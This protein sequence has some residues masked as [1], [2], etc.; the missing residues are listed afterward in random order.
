MRACCDQ[1]FMRFW[2]WWEFC[3]TAYS[4]HGKPFIW[5]TRQVDDLYGWC[6]FFLK[7][8]MDPQQYTFQ[9]DILILYRT[10][11]DK[12]V[13]TI[14]FSTLR[15]VIEAHQVQQ[16]YLDKKRRCDD[17]WQAG[18][19]ASWSG[20]WTWISQCLQKKVPHL[21]VPTSNLPY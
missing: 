8:R 14:P 4:L 12:P 3:F 13:I 11:N 18:R 1:V 21:Q 7:N 6:R 5:N 10:S 16:T 9:T 2:T 15:Q 19:K 20:S 17:W